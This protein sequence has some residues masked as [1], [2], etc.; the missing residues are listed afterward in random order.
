MP[1][2]AKDV[3]GRGLGKEA[4]DKR[5]EEAKQKREE[6]AARR[7]EDRRTAAQQQAQAEAERREKEELQ[8]QIQEA[9][10]RAR[11]QMQQQYGGDDD[12]YEGS[13]QQA[14]DQYTASAVAEAVSTGDY[15]RGFADGGLVKQMEKSGLTPKK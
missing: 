12:S 15:S 6:E 8:R 3:L 7:A 13:A 5:I 10:E 1:D 4:R 11:Q 9:Q 2:N 14:A